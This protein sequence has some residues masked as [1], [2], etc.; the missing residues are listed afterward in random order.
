[1]NNENEI[2]KVI[3]R[4][5]RKSAHHKNE[6]FQS[7]SEIIRLGS[8]D[9]LISV[10]SYSDEDHF[11]LNNPYTLGMNLAVCTLSDIFACGGKPLFFCNSLNSESSW[12]I[13]Y[14][15][16]ISKGISFILEK[17]ETGFI[18]GDFGYCGNWNFTGV[19]IGESD[20]IVK[21]KGASYGDLIYLTGEIGSGNF[22]AA[23]V[24]GK[25]SCGLDDLFKKH[26]VV[27]L[28]R[29]K[30]AALISKY[31]SSCIDTSDGLFKSLNIISEINECGF[32]IS[33]IPYFPAGIEWTNSIGLPKECLIFGECGEYELLFTINPANEK[34]LLKDADE[35]GC[36]LYRI[37]KITNDLSKIL[38]TDNQKFTLNDFKISARDF[39]DHYQYIACLTEY[40]LSK[41]AK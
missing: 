22:E 23:S 27:F 8:Q 4:N 36:K 7:D 30:E 21:R 41:K 28:L 3:L 15:D 20:R 18:G 17:C 6:F 31:A 38:L 29:I 39:T 34:K 40:L 25:L 2:I 33:N 16:S 26:P 10:D 5:F 37:G 24:L 13:D 11:R 35:A 12:N 32:N 9:Y 14:I 1:M 19:V